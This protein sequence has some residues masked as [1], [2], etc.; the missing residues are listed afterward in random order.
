MFI[1]A[2]QMAA[3]MLKMHNPDSVIKTPNIDKLAETGV[4]FDSAYC[5]SPLC[6]PSRFCLV[7]GQRPSKIGAYDNA[8]HFNADIPTF[9]HYQRLAG[10]ETSLIGKMHF[11][12]PDQLHGYENRP[13]PDIYP[14]DLGWTVN[15][16]NP[17]DRQEWFHNMDSVLQAGVAVATNQMDFD[18]E[19]LHRVSPFLLT[20]RK[21]FDPGDLS[22]QTP[23]FEHVT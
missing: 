1:M 14:A 4:V 13:M 16:D 12:G 10:Y 3:P 2:D 23:A 22:N 18:D 21:V 15:W 6:A 5:N 17:D 8:S 11:V 20:F 9:A 19:V 7:S